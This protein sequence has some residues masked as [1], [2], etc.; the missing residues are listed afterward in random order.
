VTTQSEA[1]NFALTLEEMLGELRP[2]VA[3][4]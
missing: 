4:E 3:V 1:Y 2:F